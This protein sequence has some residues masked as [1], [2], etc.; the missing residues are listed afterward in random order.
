[1]YFHFGKPICCSSKTRCGG[2]QTV[3]KGHANWHTHHV[4]R[5]A[6]PRAQAA[7]YLFI[8]RFSLWEGGVLR[9]IL[10]PMGLLSLGANPSGQKN[11]G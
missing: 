6:S 10:S 8:L 5:P 9:E 11:C 7:E 4:N 2:S 1:M 3:A